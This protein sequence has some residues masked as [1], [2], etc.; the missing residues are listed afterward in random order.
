MGPLCFNREHYRERG[1]TTS[2]GPQDG[3]P[4]NIYSGPE[5]VLPGTAMCLSCHTNYTAVTRCRVTVRPRTQSV[6]RALRHLPRPLW[7]AWM[8]LFT[9]FR[10]M[11][12]FQVKR[13]ASGA[14]LC[15]PHLQALLGTCRSFTRMGL[16]TVKLLVVTPLLSELRIF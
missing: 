12:L 4:T 2:L 5:L 1:P 7:L 8:R 10:V 15:D 13:R 14:P 9:C 3:H 11:L 6:L 16:R